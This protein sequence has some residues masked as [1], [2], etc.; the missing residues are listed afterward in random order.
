MGTKGYDQNVLR[1]TTGGI[2]KE[3]EGWD[4]QGMW[5]KQSSNTASGFEAE[6]HPLRTAVAGGAVAAAI[7]TPWDEV[8]VGV[9][10]LGRLAWTAAAGLIS[11]GKAALEF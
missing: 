10:A 5:V 7:L 8:G 9:V 11:S 6:F 3:E 4:E 1:M 2:V